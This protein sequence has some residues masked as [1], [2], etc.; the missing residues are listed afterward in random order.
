[1]PV[2]HSHRFIFIHIPRTAGTSLT[3]ALEA[4]GAEMEFDQPAFFELQS[5]QRTPEIV[6]MLRRTNPND[7]LGNLPLK[8]IPADALRAMLPQEIW[9][10]YF[11]FS[12]CR[13]PW[14]RLVSIYHWMRRNSEHSDFFRA[15][16]PDLVT[17]MQ[18]VD[19]FPDFVREY[20]MFV[21]GVAP[22]IVDSAGTILMDYVGRFEELEESAQTIAAKT[23]LRLALPH[24]NRMERGAYRDYYTDETA[25]IVER[26]FAQD[27][28][29]FGYSF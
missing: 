3:M 15:H 27:I 12:F 1:M 5:W 21:P 25:A 10:S 11:K 4:D 26:Q 19:S 29:L 16:R 8:H 22:H 23:G 13:N 7:A 28:E 9:N 17:M 20:A 18:K 24:A 6:Q 2:S 14:D